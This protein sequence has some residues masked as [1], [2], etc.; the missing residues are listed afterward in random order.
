MQTRR[1]LPE[2][3]LT[4][5]I[6]TIAWDALVL[7]LVLLLHAEW[8]AAGPLLATIRFFSYFTI[9]ANLLVALVC[10]FSLVR[11]PG[12]LQAFFSSPRVRGA[13]ALYIGVTGCVY[14]VVLSSLWAPTGFQWL[15][16][17]SLHYAVPLMYL[18]L[19]IVFAPRRTLAWSDL[20]RWLIF[21]LVYLIWA[22]VRG[23]WVHEYPY[24]FIDVDAI[25]MARALWNAV[26]VTAFLVL[27]GSILIGFNRGFARASRDAAAS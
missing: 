9:L 5:I 25:G 18:A 7:Q 3:A 1:S 27:L 13:A 4:A 12:R 17:V 20:P 11:R 16:D 6:A 14:F 19:W 24:P 8:N 21:P 15:A 22:L 10:T 2:V 26:A 23:S